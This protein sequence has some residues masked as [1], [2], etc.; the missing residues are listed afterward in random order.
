MDI[1]PFEEGYYEIH[2]ELIRKKLL[3]DEEKLK[4]EMREKLKQNSKS[5]QT[6]K[7]GKI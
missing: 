6:K 1:I 3:E 2:K 4:N 5:K 7:G